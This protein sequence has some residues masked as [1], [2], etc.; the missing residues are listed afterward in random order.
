MTFVP[1]SLVLF[2]RDARRAIHPSIYPLSSSKFATIEAQVK[3]RVPFIFFIKWASLSTRFLWDGYKLQS[4]HIVF[5]TLT[6]TTV[7]SSSVLICPDIHLFRE[8]VNSMF[9]SG[10]L[11]S[12]E[13]FFASRRIIENTNKLDKNVVPCHDA[14]EEWAWLTWQSSFVRRQGAG[15]DN[16]DRGVWGECSS[17]T[18][19]RWTRRDFGFWFFC[20]TSH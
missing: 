4:T 7:V 12:F 15:D 16:N 11:G 8:R 9:L 14:L 3:A 17:W 10:S 13:F 20:D 19:T 2:L 6:I 5:Q 1:N 18:D